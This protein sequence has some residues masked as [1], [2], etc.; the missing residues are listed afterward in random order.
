MKLSEGVEA[1][2]HSVA[3]LAALDLGHQQRDAPAIEH[4][5]PPGPGAQAGSGLGNRRGDNQGR[6]QAGHPV[7]ATKSPDFARLSKFIK[8]CK[9]R[10]A[11]FLRFFSCLGMDTGACYLKNSSQ[12][13]PRKR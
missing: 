13:F 4:H 10:R 7:R 2:I 1:A 5:T 11:I 9:Y 6:R 3:M 12:R 8:F